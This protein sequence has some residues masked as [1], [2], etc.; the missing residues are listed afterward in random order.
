MTKV[1]SGAATASGRVSWNKGKIIGAKP[2]LRP[3][4]V[5]VGPAQASGGGSCPRPCSVE[6]SHRLQTPWLR[7]R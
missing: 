1:L 5:W 3:K 7:C 2:P 4:H 6:S